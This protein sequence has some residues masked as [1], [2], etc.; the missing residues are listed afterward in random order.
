MYDREKYKNIEK[1]LDTILDNVLLLADDLG[2]KGDLDIFTLVTLLISNGYL[3]KD[4][5]YN[6]VD[7]VEDLGIYEN[8]IMELGVVPLIKDGCCRN[9][10]SLAKLMLDRFFIENDI[11]AALRITDEIDSESLLDISEQIEQESLCNHAMGIVNINDKRIAFEVVPLFGANLYSINNNITTRF[12]SSSNSHLVYNYSPFFEGKKNF[13]EITPIS[14][15]EQE[16]ILRSCNNT[17]LIIN[18]NSY[19]LEEFYEN[20]KPTIKNIEQDY[21]KVLVRR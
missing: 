15:D 20:N 16:Y 2:L 6:T 5:N 12:L 17:S 7:N 19:L 14:L 9:S 13:S 8:P 11:T 21:Q 3:S 10:A 1:Q 18:A 4:K